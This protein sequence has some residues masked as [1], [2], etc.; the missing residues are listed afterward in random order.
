MSVPALY[1]VELFVDDENDIQIIGVYKNIDVIE[2]ES[3]IYMTFSIPS[4]F[5]LIGFRALS[6]CHYNHNNKG[7]KNNNNNN[8]IERELVPIIPLSYLSKNPNA[9]V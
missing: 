2:L 9:F 1:Q 5:K 3:L 7:N 6:D 4:N 8:N